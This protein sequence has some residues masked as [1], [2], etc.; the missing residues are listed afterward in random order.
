MLWWIIYLL[1]LQGQR[2]KFYNAI[3][4]YIQ[5]DEDFSSVRRWGESWGAGIPW[6]GKCGRFD[7]H[8]FLVL[9]PQIPF[10]SSHIKK[11]D[12]ETIP[13]NRN[14]MKEEQLSK[15]V[16]VSKFFGGYFRLTNLQGIY[17][18]VPCSKESILD[19]KTMG[20][21]AMEFLWNYLKIQWKILI[22]LLVTKC[23][24]IFVLFFASFNI[25]SMCHQ[26]E[27]CFGM[28][29]EHLKVSAKT[30]L[31]AMQLYRYVFTKTTESWNNVEVQLST[32]QYI[33][34]KR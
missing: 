17:V 10:G 26:N 31:K 27:S 19:L 24:D 22:Y 9:Y 16:D 30:R 11:V 6:D 12:S 28:R 34:T 21:S 32:L 29:Y 20:A 5:I 2:V 33:Q 8:T 13:D 18:L 15:P 23:F 14:S 25:C 7:R 1:S 3:F 4:W